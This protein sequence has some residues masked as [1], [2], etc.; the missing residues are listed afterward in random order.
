M[1]SRVEQ[2]EAEMTDVKLKIDVHMRKLEE[3]NMEFTDQVN[4]E[5]TKHKLA[6][7][8]IVDSARKEF[9]NVNQGLHVSYEQTKSA[10]EELAKIIYLGP[11][12]QLACRQYQYSGISSAT[13]GDDGSKAIDALIS[14]GLATKE[15]D[16]E[17]FEKTKGWLERMGLGDDIEIR[18]LGKSPLYEVWITRNGTQSNLK[19]VGVGV[20]QVLPVIIAALHAAPGHIVMIEE[21]E[22][23]LHPLAQSILAEL[24]ATESRDRS[25]QF[26]IETHSEHLFRRM[27]TLIARNDLGKKECA[28]YFVENENSEAKFR[29]LEVDEFGRI[30]NWPK[31]FFGDSL[32]ETKAQTDIMLKRLKEIRAKNGS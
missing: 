20:S 4:V 30:G 1:D 32:G 31:S 26:I 7:G 28:L 11:V 24:F 3:Q 12:R 29:P 23:H 21:P 16:S 14:S 13:I 6:I 10:V 15:Q 18:R 25:I 17:L 9:E 19:D 5:L 2:L 22:S 8:E 27:Q